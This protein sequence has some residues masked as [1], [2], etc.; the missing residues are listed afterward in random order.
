[1]HTYKL[2][3][4]LKLLNNRIKWDMV[5]LLALLLLL[6]LLRRVTLGV[7]TNIVP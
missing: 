7:A 1:M 3:K 5:K 6:N 2:N 4:V